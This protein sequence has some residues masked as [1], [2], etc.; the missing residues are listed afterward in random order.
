[1]AW[2]FG[3]SFAHL[4]ASDLT[5][6]WNG[7]PSQWAIQSANPRVTGGKY[8]EVNT[9]TGAFTKTI[10][11][12]STLVAGFGFYTT[13]GG[14]QDIR[15]VAF[16]DGGEQISLRIGGSG[17]LFVSRNG[18]TLATAVD[19]LNFGQ[20]YYIEFKAVIHNTAGAYAVRVN[21]GTVN[22]IPDATNVNTRGSGTNN[23]ATQVAFHDGSNHFSNTHRYSDI[24]VLDGQGTSLNDFLGDVRYEVL[25]PNGAGAYTQ[26]TPSVGNNWETVDE[27]QANTTDYVT[28]TANDQIDSYTFTDLAGTPA[29]I[30][31]AVVNVFAQKTDAAN[32]SIA[33]FCKAS[34]GNETVGP[35]LALGTTW[36]V[37]QR[38]LKQEP[39]AGGGREWTAARING[40]QFGV[41]SRP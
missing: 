22:G 15:I 9:I 34:D 40:S 41:K 12:S 24:Y 11:A 20:W 2:V 30:H 38:V 25:Y 14:S 5:K 3:E 35:D 23:F 6:K 29:T 31:V 19:S 13:G 27:A 26:W 36:M 17:R 32:K 4:I 1:M 10:P 37:Y 39:D 8:V 21:G 7:F 28:S 33:I 16:F 18:T